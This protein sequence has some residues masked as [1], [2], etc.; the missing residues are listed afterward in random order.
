MQA[1]LAPTIQFETETG[2]PFSDGYS[3]DK[4]TAALTKFVADGA[5]ESDPLYDRYVELLDRR[6]RLA[7]M[8]AEHSERGGADVLAQR[9]D[10]MGMEALG[11]LVD[12]SSDQMTIHTI[13]AYRMFLGRA[14]EPGSR[15][16]PIIGGK[17]VA[18]ALKNLWQLTQNDNPYADWALVRH[19]HG[20]NS[21]LEHLRSEIKAAEAELDGMRKRGLS[22]AVLS[23]SS[24]QAVNLGFRSP[25][26]YA[27]SMLIVEYDYF[28]RIQKTLQRKNLKTDEQARAALGKVSRAILSVFYSTSRFDRWLSQSEL[29]ELTRLDWINE[30]GDAAKRVEAALGIFGPVPS[31]VYKGDIAPSHSRRRY[32]LSEAERAVLKEVGG[33]LEDEEHVAAT[34]AP[35][36]AADEAGAPAA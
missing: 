25:Y 10:V 19:E 34:E 8:Q 31:A 27:I 14:R 30:E 36:A 16:A 5:K 18:S 26:G 24:P 1:V 6:E 7:Q 4:E 13:E 29:R 20:V 22:L 23:S 11:G 21:V 9:S 2:S 12:E 3:I 33:W 28:V 35:S 32:S 17:R 15:H